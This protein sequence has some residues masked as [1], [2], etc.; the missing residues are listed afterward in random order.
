MPV[1]TLRPGQR[2]WAA[3]R[4][5]F[6]VDKVPVD[7]DDAGKAA[8]VVENRHEGDIVVREAVGRADL[9]SERLVA[10]AQRIIDDR[11]RDLLV[12]RV[13]VAE[14]DDGRQLRIVEARCRLVA[15]VSEVRPDAD[16]LAVLC[17]SGTGHDQGNHAVAFSDSLL[18][19]D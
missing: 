15:S 6:L 11:D 17:P 18:E 10:L 14:L 3:V 7:L 1:G 9:D 8:V 4:I 19:L 13:A 5:V 12:G 16:D 2:Q